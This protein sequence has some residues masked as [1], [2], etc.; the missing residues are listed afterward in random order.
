MKNFILNIINFV[1]V[2]MRNCARLVLKWNCARLVLKLWFGFCRI[3][4]KVGLIKLQD[5]LPLSNPKTL[6]PPPSAS[7]LRTQAPNPLR[8]LAG[9]S[10]PYIS[11]RFATP[12]Y[13]YPLPDSLSIL[14]G[15]N[16]TFHA[17]TLSPSSFWATTVGQSPPATWINKTGQEFTEILTACDLTSS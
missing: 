6:R 16:F 13:L 3:R 14:S 10:Y 2:A 4:L 5:P 15:V 8:L 7:L 17:R 9:A 11:S 1:D 12:P